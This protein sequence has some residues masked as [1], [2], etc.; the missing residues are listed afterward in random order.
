MFRSIIDKK[1]FWRSY[2]DAPNFC[3]N[4]GYRGVKTVRISDKQHTFF[5]LKHSLSR[6]SRVNKIM[7]HRSLMINLY[8]R[9][10]MIQNLRVE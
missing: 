10:I 1:L 8:G 4:T 9:G 6:L 2:D 7:I 5:A 3:V